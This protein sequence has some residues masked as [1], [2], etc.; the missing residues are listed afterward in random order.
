MKLALGAGPFTSE[1]VEVL[2]EAERLGFDSAWGGETY[3]HDC[4]T[5][6]GWLAAQTETIKLGTIVSIIDARAP[7]LTAMTAMTLDHLSGGRYTL[8]LGFS[9]PQ[10]VEGWYGRPFPRPLARMREYIDIVRKVMARREAVTYDG[11]FYQLPYRGPGAQGQGKPLKSITHPLR[12]DQPIFLAAEGPKNV[13]LTAELADGWSAF[14]LSPHSDAFYRRCLD[15]GF[16]RRPGGRP[17]HFD[18][19]GQVQIAIAP[20]V[21]EAADQV[22]PHIAFMVGGMGA[23]NANFHRDAL[24]RIGFDEECARI[25]R[26]WAEGDRA[27]AAAAVPTRMVECLALVGPPDKIRRDLDAWKE[28][29]ITILQPMLMGASVDVSFVRLLA[30]LVWNS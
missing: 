7:T 6:I 16:A 12:P 5:P 1:H 28:T 25:A 4:F 11:E 26:L 21:E 9:G 24:A 17:A 22:R 3:G 27:G 2:R 13:A 8:G 14:Y 15:E 23:S 10:V 29:S 20:D 30:D 19:I 18:V